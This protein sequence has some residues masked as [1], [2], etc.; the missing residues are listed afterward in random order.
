MLG[1]V[2]HYSEEAFRL[3]GL[4]PRRPGGPPQ[5]EETGQLIHPEDRERVL[6]Q[7][8]QIFRD[9]AEYEQDYRI[10]LPDGTVR[11]LHSIGHPV[12]DQAGELVEY[13]GTV[14]DVTE[15]KRA[16]QRLLA[17]H[18]VARILAEA[19]TV[20]EATP[21]I[22]QAV[23]ECMGWDVGVRWRIDREAD[24]LRCADV[25]RKPSVEAAQFEAATRAST[26]RSGSGLPGRVWASRTPAYIADVLHDPKFSRA[27]IAARE[28]LQGCRCP[29]DP[30]GQRGPRRHRF[31]QP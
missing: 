17:Q 28:G 7:L 1:K 12:L 10:V 11:H 30:A 4:D 9:K 15:R 2:T 14:I 26:F 19:T 3:F 20:E 6:E 23:C 25:W 5:L 13:F 21:K 16:E 29:S 8:A 18:R 27:D 31:L 24:V 22:L